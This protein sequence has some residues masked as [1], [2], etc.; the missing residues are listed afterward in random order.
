MNGFISVTLIFSALD[1]FV[2]QSGD[3]GM[4]SGR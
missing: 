3:I 4:R 2:R 1:L